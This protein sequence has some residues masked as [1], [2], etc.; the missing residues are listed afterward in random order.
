M[1]PSQQPSTLFSLGICCKIT[2]QCIVFAYERCLL[3]H[4]LG[5]LL[6]YGT[7]S[8]NLGL[9]MVSTVGSKSGSPLNRWKKQNHSCNYLILFTHILHQCCY[10]YLQQWLFCKQRFISSQGQLE[11]IIMHVSYHQN[12]GQEPNRKTITTEKGDVTKRSRCPWRLKTI[13][14]RPFLNV[15]TL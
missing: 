2:R 12:T 3:L 15:C 4:F 1:S 7:H 11:A 14:I 9:G 6:N 13:F 8:D 10:Y 5:A